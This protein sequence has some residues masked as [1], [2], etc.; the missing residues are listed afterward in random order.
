MEKVL[1]RFLKY[2]Q[3]DT[4]SK[5]RI[6]G[7]EYKNPSTDTQLIMIASL[8]EELI[9]FGV[10]EKSIQRLGDGSMI[11]NLPPGLGYENAVKICLAAH[12]DT[13]PGVC[14]KANP[15]IHNYE[16]G[17]IV[18]PNNNV[19]ILAS[20]LVDLKGK[21]IVTSD[22]TSLLGA[23]DKAGVAALM[24]VIESLVTEKN[25]IHGQL[26]FWFCV[27]EEI[28][29][30]G[31]SY[32]NK[33]LAE[34]FDL[35]LTVDGGRLGYIDVGCFYCRKFNMV[36]RGRSAHPGMSPDKLKPS[37]VAAIE[38]LH[39]MMEIYPSPQD[40]IRNP[41]L[42][43][44]YPE[45]IEGNASQTIVNMVPRCFTQKESDEMVNA[46]INIAQS[47][48]KKYGCEVEVVED[49]MVCV[50]NKE[51]IDS[52]PNLLNMLHQIHQDFWVETFERSIRGGTDGA[53]FNKVY[54]K[55][56][57]PNIG[58]GGSNFHG[59]Q[60]FLVVEELEFVTDI[61]IYALSQYTY[62]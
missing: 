54:S 35:F 34:S 23:D 42:G 60:E 17:D 5:Q 29:E 32:I 30:L 20:D 51:A 24:T 16:G 40:G 49:N 39:R 13:Y 57:T 25:T 3:M 41:N 52:K 55:T 15:I 4:A 59:E 10:P 11:L 28:G 58:Y 38:F 44:F 53:M 2:V 22:G 43:F 14:G 47:M 27:D 9:S 62:I 33:E 37:H 31:I 45:K 7:E 19:V 36:F 21:Q 18:L 46:A 61:L 56:P 50:N 1:E 8:V 48:A 26:T 12:V 6:C